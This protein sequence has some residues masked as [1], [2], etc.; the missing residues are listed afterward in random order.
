MKLKRLIILYLLLNLATFCEIRNYT[1]KSGFIKYKIKSANIDGEQLYYFDDYGKKESSK[2]N[3]E[4]KAG[5]EIKNLKVNS[6]RIEELLF[7]INN[8]LNEFFF[9]TKNRL[10]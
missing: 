9:I 10:Q 4:I 5:K 1:E 8:L 3:L 7:I 6:L 2:I